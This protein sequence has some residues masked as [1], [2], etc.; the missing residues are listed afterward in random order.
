M[1]RRDDMMKRRRKIDAARIRQESYEESRS[2]EASIRRLKEAGCDLPYYEFKQSF[3]LIFDEQIAVAKKLFSSLDSVFVIN[4]DQYHD[5][6]WKPPV[7][8]SW[9]LA[10]VNVD[11]PTDDGSYGKAASKEESSSLQG[12]CS[13]Y[14]TSSESFKSI[15]VLVDKARSNPSDSQIEFCYQCMLLSLL[16]EFGHLHDAE[17]RINIDPLI[18]RF[19]TVEA[20]A[21]ANCFA[22]DR[23][24]DMALPVSYETLFDAIKELA[25]LPGTKG[26][27][28]RL[29]LK[30][31]IPREIRDWTKCKL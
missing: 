17:N 29:V 13:F 15:I 6:N 30:N 1:V 20:E 26:E 5:A 8:S 24:A 7:D 3:K 27:I 11:D 2:V 12:Y 4:D 18:D 25:N 14:L 22:L 28:G 19:R 16:H 9:K 23:L 10:L 31:H 21:Y